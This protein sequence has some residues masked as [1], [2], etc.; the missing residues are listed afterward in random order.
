MLTR[1]LCQRFYDWLK[2]GGCLFLDTFDLKAEPLAVQFK[3]GFRRVLQ[4][5]APQLQSKRVPFFWVTQKQLHRLVSGVFPS[6]HV[7]SI[8]C[9]TVMGPGRKLQCLAMKK[10]SIPV[11][12][13][14]HFAAV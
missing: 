11:D 2:P 10:P 3:E 9:Q 8:P 7:R 6:V 14:Q 5:V 4:T 13:L 1:E 12:L